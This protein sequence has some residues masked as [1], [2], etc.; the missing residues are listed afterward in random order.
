MT[1]AIIYTPTDHFEQHTDQCLDYCAQ[2][3]YDVAGVVR[4]D[5]HTAMQLACE[6]DVAGVVVVA[7]VDH[8]DPHRRPR[9]E[10]VAE[11]PAIGRASVPRTRVIRRG[12]AA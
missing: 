12:G 6:G 5:W 1:K 11:Q 9:V 7:R 2:R 10:V 8:L 3:G 4:D